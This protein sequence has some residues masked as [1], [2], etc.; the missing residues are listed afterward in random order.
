MTEKELEQY[1]ISID[2][3]QYGYC[4][5]IPP[6]TNTG[7]FEISQGWYKI[8]KDLIDELISLG[9][10]KRLIQCKEKFGGLR[11]YIEGGTREL[12]DVIRKYERLSTETCELCGEKG[13]NMIINRWLVTRCLQ[14]K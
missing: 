11:F 6:M 8:V 7:M 9:W 5:D 4:I 10:N 1:L 12:H 13:E 2:G 3:I 14:H